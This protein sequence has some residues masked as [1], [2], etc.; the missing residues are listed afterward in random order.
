M[1]DSRVVRGRRQLRQRRHRRQ[2]W[3]R[4]RDDPDH[5]DRFMAEVERQAELAWPGHTLVARDGM[6]LTLG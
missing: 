6:E 3:P 4:D 1:P 2:R 5:D